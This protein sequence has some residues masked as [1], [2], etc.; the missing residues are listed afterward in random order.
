MPPTMVGELAM[1]YWIMSSALA[2]K[3]HCLTALI[4]HGELLVQVAIIMLGMLLSSA[5]MV[6]GSVSLKMYFISQGK[7]PKWL[8]LLREYIIG[9]PEQALGWFPLGLGLAV[10]DSLLLALCSISVILPYFCSQ[11]TLP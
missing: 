6:R 3:Q 9:M 7:A 4:Q 1:S 8:C 5:L 10:E 2:A 11:Q